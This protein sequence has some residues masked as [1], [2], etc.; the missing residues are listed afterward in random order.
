MNPK[1]KFIYGETIPLKEKR[2]MAPLLPGV[3][4][5]GANGEMEREVHRKIRQHLSKKL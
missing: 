3:L 5:S 2:A 4:L 1:I